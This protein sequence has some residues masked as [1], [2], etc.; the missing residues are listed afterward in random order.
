MQVVRQ[1]T[2]HLIMR[3]KEIE[4][5]KKNLTL[6]QTQ[7]SLLVGMLLGDGHLET[8]D[9]GRTYRLKVEHSTIQ[10]EYVEWLYEQFK[11]FVRTPPQEKKKLLHGKSHTSYSFSTY[12]LGAFRFYAQQFYAGRKKVMPKLIEKLINPLALAI[13]FMDDGS[14]KSE[15]H[16]TYIIHALGYNKNNLELV[17]KVFQ[18]KFGIAIGIHKQYDRWRIYVYSDSAMKFRK[19]IE[20]YVIPSLKY[21]LGN[22]V[23][24]E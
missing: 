14:C 3:S 6:T 1:R 4:E 7:R 13:W 22:T 11:S 2:T 24:K 8:Q 5:F 18:E 17:K 15:R 9:H 19:L 16:S 12:S 20:P 21:K 10:K 23:P